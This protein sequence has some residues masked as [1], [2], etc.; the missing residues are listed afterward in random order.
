MFEVRNQPK[1]ACR[2]STFHCDARVEVP[3]QDESAIAVNVHVPWAVIANPGQE[4]IVPAPEF[5][6]V[7]RYH[8]W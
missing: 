5:A 3:L 4:D 2:R 6:H 7:K 1:K 8:G